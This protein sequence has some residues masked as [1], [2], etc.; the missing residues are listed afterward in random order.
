MITRACP[1]KQNGAE[2]CFSTSKRPRRFAE[3]EFDEFVQCHDNKKQYE[4]GEKGCYKRQI[5][6]QKRKN[7]PHEATDDGKEKIDEYLPF[8]APAAFM[9]TETIKF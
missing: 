2:S 1:S 5:S 6:A 8:G 7:Y 9:K 4:Q 3:K